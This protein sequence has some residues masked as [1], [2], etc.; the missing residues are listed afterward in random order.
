MP[1]LILIAAVGKNRVIGKHNRLI[2]HL[3]E[4]MA[5]FKAITHG[6]TVLMGRKTWES[7]PDR[8]R[9]LPGR[10]N[11][12][13]SR[14]PGFSPAGAEVAPSLAAALAMSSPDDTVFVI[15]GAEIYTQALTLA[16]TLLLTEVDDA[17]DGDVWFPVVSPAEWQETERRAGT[18]ATPPAYDFV[19]YQRRA[20][21]FDNGTG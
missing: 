9:P 16:E 21:S 4:D 20:A 13:L 3:P 5:Y 18:P 17:P 14:Q 12:V 15:G 6:H 11:R 1:H 2:W 10:R 7:L 8:F 19:T